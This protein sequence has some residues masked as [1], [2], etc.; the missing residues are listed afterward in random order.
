MAYLPYNETIDSM[1]KEILIKIRVAMNGVTSELMADKGVQYSR[2]FGVAF[3]NLRT[4]AKGYEQNELLA[5]HLWL[6]SIRETKILAILLFPANALTEKKAV[7][8][9][10]ECDTI[11]LVEYL[12]AYL[13]VE[14]PFASKLIKKLAHAEDEKMLIAAYAL[15]AQY[16][17]KFKP[18]ILDDFLPLLRFSSFHLSAKL[19]Q[20]MLFFLLYAVS[21]QGYKALVLAEME[22]L[23]EEQTDTI[24]TW[25]YTEFNS[26]IED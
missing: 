5:T 7:E 10:K 4:I 6:K 11:E 21:Q 3:P 16:C 23:H 19:A 24:A 26:L 17:K 15:A 18:L 12:C 13:L 1:V 22:R 14:M 9:V 20:S 25:L 2:N 8:W